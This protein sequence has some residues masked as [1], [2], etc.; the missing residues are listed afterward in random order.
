MAAQELTSELVAEQ[1]GLHLDY[2]RVVVAA[3]HSHSGID[4]VGLW[5]PMTSGVREEEEYIQQLIQT[6]A[7]TATEAVGKL[8]DAELDWGTAQS[9]NG[10]EDL[11]DDDETV[12][13]LRGRSP[14]GETLF[15]LTRWVGH[16]TSYGSHGNAVSADWVGAFRHYMEAGEGGVAA[17]LDT[18][19]A[20]AATTQP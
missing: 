17:F 5:G 3:S 1:L 20:L 8:G 6:V 4:S 15:T 11:A 19:S 18:L 13:V 14:A 16:P 9:P 7:Q 12:W 10:D 2:H